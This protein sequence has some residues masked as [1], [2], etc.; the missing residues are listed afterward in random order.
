MIETIDNAFQLI[1]GGICVL[2]AAGKVAASRKRE[3]TLLLLYYCSYFLGNLYWLLYLLFYQR[4]PQ[5]FYVADLSWWAGYLFL[6]LLLR[7]AETG[8]GRKKQLLPW[9]GPA[10]TAGMC[11]FFVQRGEYVSNMIYAV[12]MGILLWHAIRGMLPISGS[13]KKQSKNTMLCAVT[14]F[15][16]A[17][18]YAEWTASCF[19]MGDTLK[20]PYFW[21][22]TLLTVSFPL[23]LPAVRK[24]AEE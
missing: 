11:I 7:E 3:W 15:F 17:M 24:A 1:V 8:I 19:W 9:L 21:F 10:F 16:F 22:D 14:L 13:E 12:L 5:Y 4:T 20:N 18:E 6:I 23:F 2:L